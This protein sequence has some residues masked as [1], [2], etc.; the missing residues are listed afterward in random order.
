ME[1][2]RIHTASRPS[3][4]C[5]QHKSFNPK[6]HPHLPSLVNGLSDI[7]SIQPTTPKSRDRITDNPAPLH[8]YN[9]S[10]RETCNT[11]II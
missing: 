11:I 6:I 1:Y 5:I 2:I 3:V 9:I 10:Y 7:K 8:V 4:Q